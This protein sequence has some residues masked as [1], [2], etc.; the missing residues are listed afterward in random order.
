MRLR[1]EHVLHVHGVAGAEERAVEDR[2]RDDRLLP[3][4]VGSW[5]RHGS[6]PSSQ[7][8]VDEAQV[9]AVCAR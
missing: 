6:M 2:V 5:K 1:A 9:V 3:V 4:S 8:R 7:R